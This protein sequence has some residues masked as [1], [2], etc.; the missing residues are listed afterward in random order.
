MYFDHL[1]FKKHILFYGLST[2]VFPFGRSQ[3]SFVGF[4]ENQ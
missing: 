3:D 1:F 2:T 4:P